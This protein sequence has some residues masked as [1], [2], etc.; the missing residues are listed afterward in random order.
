MIKRLFDIVFSIVGIILLSPLMLIVFYLIKYSKKYGDGGPVIFKQQRV[1]QY[2]KIFHIHKFRTM[3]INAERQQN[4]VTASNDVR[5]T[6][7]GHYLRKFKLDEIPQLFDVLRG[8]MS[9]VGPRPEVPE[10]VALYPLDIKKIVLSV[11][12]GITE[13]ASIIMIDESNVLANYSTADSIREVYVNKIMPQKLQ[14]AV[15]YVKTRTF[16]Q[17]LLILLL[18]LIQI[19]YRKKLNLNFNR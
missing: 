6:K 11:K 16:K 14:F 17:D 4:N 1:G 7:L 18:T 9:F 12:P 15:K 8:V 10:F 5:I 13:W 2:G 19:F 3:V